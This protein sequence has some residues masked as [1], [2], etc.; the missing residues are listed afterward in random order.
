MWSMHSQCIMIEF[1]DFDSHF[2]GTIEKSRQILDTCIMNIYKI[3]RS[4]ST[5]HDKCP[6]Y[7]IVTDDCSC[8]MTVEFWWCDDDRMVISDGYMSPSRSER[9][10][11]IH[12]MRLKGG[13]MN[14]GA[15]FSSKSSHEEY[16]SSTDTKISIDYYGKSISIP[17]KCDKLF[18]IIWCVSHLEKPSIDTIYFSLTDTASTWICHLYFTKAM[19]KSRNEIIR[20]S[21]FFEEIDFEILKLD[22]R[23]IYSKYIITKCDFWSQA[24]YELYHEMYVRN[25]RYIFDLS[26]FK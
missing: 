17:L 21:C 26:C 25:I 19:K 5:Y 7:D 9:I 23:V 11:E 14:G 20:S 22:V 13:K 4:E 3:S 2:S 12:D 1:F 18:F 15:I 24:L 16:D 8:Q 10:D 6:W